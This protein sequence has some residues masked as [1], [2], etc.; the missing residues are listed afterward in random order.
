MLT[1]AHIERRIP[2]RGTM[3]LLDSV[4]HWDAT[5]I[6]CQADAPGGDHPLANAHHVPSVA[7]IEYAAQAAAVHG[8]LRGDLD[9]PRVGML[10]KVT[11]VE[12][13][14]GGIDA[15][16]G[17]LTIRAE[18]LGEVASGCLY[19]FDVADERTAIA[20]GRLLVAFQS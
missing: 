11:E 6:V 18:L 19:A 4:Q 1:R 16:G 13:M 14:A 9:A 8:S 2:H 7:A 5:N 20:R 12:L 10:A 17:R 15:A 3:C